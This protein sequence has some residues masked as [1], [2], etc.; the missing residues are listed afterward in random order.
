LGYDVARNDFTIGTQN[1]IAFG[2]G[3]RAL[4]HAA[5]VVS[6]LRYCRLV[7]LPHPGLVIL[8]TP[9]N[10]LRGRDEPGE[11]KVSKEVQNAFYEDLARNSGEDQII[12]MENE[13]P[14]EAVRSLM[15]YQH[16]SGNPDIDRPGFY[17]LRTRR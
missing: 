14:S 3:H 16:F 4:T 9:L 15:T 1:R 2:K 12:V 10:P 6:I 8:D 13:D 5:V 7:D 17:P 11:E